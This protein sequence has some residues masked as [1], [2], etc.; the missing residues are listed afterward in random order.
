MV[1]VAGAL[2]E[3]A[4]IRSEVGGVVD[5]VWDSITTS[6]QLITT[7]ARAGIELEE[8][9][10]IQSLTSATHQPLTSSELPTYIPALGLYSCVFSVLIYCSSYILTR[11]LSRGFKE[12]TQ[13]VNRRLLPLQYQNIWNWKLLYCTLFCMYELKISKI[14]KGLYWSP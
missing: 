3:N 8:A 14:E 7:S 1:V 9:S 5:S 11:A 12:K 2:N 13:W 6:T 10:L 4:R